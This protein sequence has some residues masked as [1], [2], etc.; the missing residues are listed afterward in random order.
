MPS[1]FRI[2][3]EDLLRGKVIPPGWRASVI[4]AVTQKVAKTDGSTNTV[5]TF[6]VDDKSPFDG[7]PV[8]RVFS[9]KAPGFAEGFASAVLGRPIKLEGEEF[10]F[11]RAVG[12]QIK[13]YYTNEKYQGRMVNRAED[14]AP[15]S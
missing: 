1:L 7:V 14:F 4:K 5:V 15:L 10:D 8:D 13:V 12:K 11:D 2:S 3:R 6:V 9:E